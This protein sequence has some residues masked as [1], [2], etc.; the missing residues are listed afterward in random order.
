MHADFDLHFT[1]SEVISQVLVVAPAFVR[2]CVCDGWTIVGSV[3]L[4]LLKST[5]A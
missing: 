5:V 2:V 3:Y 1:G 4:T